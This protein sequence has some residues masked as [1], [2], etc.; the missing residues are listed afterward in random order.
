MKMA[1]ER[2]DIERKGET[3]IQE[4]LLYAVTLYFSPTPIL[5][6]YL[7]IKWKCLILLIL[8]LFCLVVYLYFRFFTL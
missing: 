5:L 3:K 2:Q 4:F 7:L 1:K 6:I 8:S